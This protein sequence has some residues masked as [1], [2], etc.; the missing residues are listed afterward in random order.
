M[1]S[2]AARADSSGTLGGRS[3]CLVPA[4]QQRQQCLSDDEIKLQSDRRHI[5]AMRNNI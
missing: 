4:P 2:A 1:S 3:E 5:K